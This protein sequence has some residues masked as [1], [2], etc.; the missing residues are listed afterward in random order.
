MVRTLEIRKLLVAVAVWYF[1]AINNPGGLAQVG[2][3][4]AFGT[5]L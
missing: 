4:S 3:T 1:V 2:P 5:P